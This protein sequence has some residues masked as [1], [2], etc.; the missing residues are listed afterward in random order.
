LDRGNSRVDLDEVDAMFGARSE[1]S[2]PALSNG[3]S[4]LKICFLAGTLEHGGAER[5]LFYWL[6]TLGQC[7]ADSTVLSLDRGEFWEGPIQNLGVSVVWVGQERS[8][9]RRLFRITKQLRQTPAQAIQSQH[10]FAN[11]YVGMVGKILG[12]GSIG[13]IR[14]DGVTEVLQSGRIGGQLN[15]RL[16]ATLAANS[17]R[18]VRYA[19]G[20]GVSS[21]HLFFLP[22]VIDTQRFSPVNHPAQSPFTLLAVGR[23][24]EQKRLD[25]FLLVL[26]RLR[27]QL[28]LDVK[29]LIVGPSRAGDAVRE[30]LES[31]A[32]QLGLLP[33]AVQFYGAVADM[34]RIYQQASVVLLTSDYEGTPNVLLEAMAC[35]LPVVSTRVG[36]VPEIVQDRQT[37]FLLEAE[38][39]DGLV[40]AAAQL[41]NDPNLCVRMGRAARAFVEKN[42]SLVRLPAYLSELYRLALPNRQTQLATGLC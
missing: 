30:R 8:R 38:D 40:A 24:V 27:Q 36:G 39:C 13:A 12:I 29:G 1:A 16:P 20:Q 7:G 19:V 5:Q 21:K 18:G 6:R 25:R 4:G 23:L 37:G 14:N 28:R 2:S 15:L 41:V 26:S 34:T 11:G 17:R 32:R 33:D 42:H 9:L 35:G 22:N 3:L 10:F 31:L